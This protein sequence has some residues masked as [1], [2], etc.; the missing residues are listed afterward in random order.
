LASLSQRTGPLNFIE[1][2]TGNLI[3]ICVDVSVPP[4][5]MLTPQFDAGNLLPPRA[6]HAF[7]F[8]V[9]CRP[10]LVN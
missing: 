10:G 1:Q 5:K 8:V 4:L 6:L 9:Q 7:R 2:A 3:G